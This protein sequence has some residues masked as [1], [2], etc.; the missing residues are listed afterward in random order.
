MVIFQYRIWN[1]QERIGV[2]YDLFWLKIWLPPYRSPES[3]H[4]SPVTW[5]T[6]LTLYDKTHQ[7]LVGI[8]IFLTQTTG[9]H[10]ITEILWKLALI[11]HILE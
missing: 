5:C 8:S 11:T 3:N 1:F 4:N 9:R 6:H 2:I 7:R 10:N